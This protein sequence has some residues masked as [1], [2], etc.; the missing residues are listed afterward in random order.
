MLFC[1]GGEARFH[2]QPTPFNIA[3]GTQHNA[4]INIAIEA[5]HDSAMEAL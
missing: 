1:R 3:P 4:Q 2:Q 5:I